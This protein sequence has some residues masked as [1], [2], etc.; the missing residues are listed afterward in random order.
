[1]HLTSVLTALGQVKVAPDYCNDCQVF[2]ET[3]IVNNSVI[4]LWR[5]RT[6]KAC[7]VLPGHYSELCHSLANSAFDTLQSMIFDGHE[8]YCNK[9]EFCD[10]NDEPV[11]A[12]DPCDACVNLVTDVQFM[13]QNDKD[14]YKKLIGNLE[15]AFCATQEDDAEVQQQCH[16][17]MKIVETF[18]VEVLN[19]QTAKDICTEGFMC[20]EDPPKPDNQL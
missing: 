2:V 3:N 17:R 5:D 4:R 10:D 1:M 20:K 11:E 14:M 15:D 13:T 7:D 16:D 9:L 12:I 19:G 6:E 18:A 8:G